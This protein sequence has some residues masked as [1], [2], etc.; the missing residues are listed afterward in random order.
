M[1]CDTNIFAIELPHPTKPMSSMS[2][3]VIAMMVPDIP[4]RWPLGG[5]DSGRT[6]PLIVSGL[7]TSVGNPVGF[8]G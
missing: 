2:D 1:G 6:E 3:V 5:Q 7:L 4:T 8:R